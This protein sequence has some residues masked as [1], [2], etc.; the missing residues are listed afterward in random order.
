MRAKAQT[1]G[2]A[3]AV[4]VFT[5]PALLLTSACGAVG[6]TDGDGRPGEAAV[7]SESRLEEAGLAR[8]DVPGYQVADDRA[9]S[10]PEGQPEADAREC[11]PIADI[12]GDEPDGRA[13]D[14]V[15]RGLGTPRDPDLAVSVSLSSYE[16]ATAKDVL[17]GLRA[18][19]RD[20]GSAFLATV[21]ER[22]GRYEDIRA[23]DYAPEG[24]DESVSFTATATDSDTRL[25]LHIVVVRGGSTVVRMMALSFDAKRTDPRVPRR[26]ADKQM[27]KLAGV[28]GS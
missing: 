14:T 21:Q 27:E 26:I 6:G 1:T 3:L 28:T 10:G 11:Q 16:P 15:S 2:T 12:L 22:T 9:S 24:G 4:A 7:L 18:A 20:C 23:V 8:G 17:A 5:V 25:P 19:L 13:L